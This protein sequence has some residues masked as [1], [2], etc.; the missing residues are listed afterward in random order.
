[1]GAKR[2]KMSMISGGSAVA[3]M[4][5][6]SGC[7]GSN[8]QLVAANNFATA[9]ASIQQAYQAG[10]QR[11]SSG[12]LNMARQKLEQAKKAQEDGDDELAQRLAAQAEV[13]AQ[14]AAATAGNK[15]MQAAVVDLRG[16]IQTLR[17]E[18]QRGQ[19]RSQ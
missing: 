8:E 7:A 6:L 5:T 14:L 11:Y 9:E 10:A 13:D 4:F 16:G 3:L 1:M 19:Q 2:M 18:I 17:D 15:E 12:E